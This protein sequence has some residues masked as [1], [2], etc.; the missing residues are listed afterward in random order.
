MPRTLR[1]GR[2]VSSV[3]E[4]VVLRLDAEDGTIGV[5]T[6]Y[7]RGTPLLEAAEILCR[8]LDPTVGWRP[9]D[10]QADLRA[11]FGPG[12]GTMIRAASLFDIALWDL[13]GGVDP[14]RRGA[15]TG[16]R[17]PPMMAVAGYFAD[18][19]SSDEIRAEALRFLE[20]GASIVKVMVPG[21][22]EEMDRR[23]F[24]EIASVV[25]GRARLGVDL[26]GTCRS[27]DDAWRAAAAFSALG[28]EFLEDPFPGHPIARLSR[29]A[30]TGDLPLAV[31]ED[32]VGTDLI[33]ELATISTYLRVDATASGGYTFARTALDVA[34]EVGGRV[35]PHVFPAIHA[36][37]AGISD[38]VEAIEIIPAYVGADPID[39]ITDDL[40]AQPF[41]RLAFDWRAVGLHA[42][43]Q[44]SHAVD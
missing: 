28:A 29:Y 7:T 35:M 5:A 40:V 12:W 8:A 23:I 16:Q 11:R 43:A 42:S 15:E 4:Y 31:G 38:V 18:T 36:P 27:V 21:V 22:E 2:A 9:E 26:H 20:E 44:W 32:L 30:E 3:R 10:Q 33:R 19:R 39:L 41:G 34:A 14:V 37:L 6:G 24:T 25:R 17:H 13:W 1:L